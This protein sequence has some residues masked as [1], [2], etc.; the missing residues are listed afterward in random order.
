MNS[1]PSLET[2]L[3]YYIVNEHCELWVSDKDHNQL[4]IKISC[5]KNLMQGGEKLC[6]QILYTMDYTEVILSNYI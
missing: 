6:I 3:Y 4:W 5:H 1:K 2:Y